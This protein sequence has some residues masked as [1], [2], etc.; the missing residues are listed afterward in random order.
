M[1]VS[2]IEAEDLKELLAR[3]APSETTPAAAAKAA[4]A[5]PSMLSAPEDAFLISGLDALVP[6]PFDALAPAAAFVNGQAAPG[7]VTEPVLEQEPELPTANGMGLVAPADGLPHGE[8][9]R[10]ESATTTET[11]PAIL[12]L[13][14]IRDKL[15]AI[16]QRAHAAGMLSRPGDSPGSALFPAAPAQPPKS[17]PEKALPPA[18][19][20][21]S[22]PMTSPQRRR[23]ILADSVPAPTPAPAASLA[24]PF[25]VFEPSAGTAQE[26]LAAF[27][28]RARDILHEEGGHLLVMNDD[29]ELLWGGEAKASLVLSAMMAWNATMRASAHAACG[30]LPVMR[31]PLASGHALTVIPCETAPGTVL[32]IAVAAPAA[33]E[34]APA[35]ELRNALEAAMNE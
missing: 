27:A 35:M 28:A 30:R 32:H 21:T 29:G 4:Q 33:L 19:S 22:A 31:Q 12:P 16:R 25:P 23:A 3:I 2:W 7:S 15:R 5:A 6:D 34:D 24:P 18:A 8:A 13:S 9:A 26:R 1:Q 11:A 10:A 14:R 20:E 17:T